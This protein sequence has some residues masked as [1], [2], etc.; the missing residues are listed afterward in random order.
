MGD[1]IGDDFEILSVHV[2]AEF[3]LD[4]IL[5]RFGEKISEYEWSPIPAISH[6]QIQRD[7]LTVCR[8]R[9]NCMPALPLSPDKES[10]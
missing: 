8:G 9:S 3:E 5:A 6:F 10:Q 4:G 7:S 1:F 2:S